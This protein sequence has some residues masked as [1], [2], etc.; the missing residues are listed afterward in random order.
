[1]LDDAFKLTVDRLF[2]NKNKPRDEKSEY[3]V[4]GYEDEANMW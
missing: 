3:P 2:A 4:P 1:M